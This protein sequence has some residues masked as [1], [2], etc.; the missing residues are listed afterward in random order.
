MYITQLSSFCISRPLL[1]TLLS[2]SCSHMQNPISLLHIYC[3][4]FCF[5]L[6]FGFLMEDISFRKIQA[7]V[8]DSFPLRLWSQSPSHFLTD[9]SSSSLFRTEQC[10]V[11]CEYPMFFIRSLQ[12]DA[13]AAEQGLC[14]CPWRSYRRR[15]GSSHSYVPQRCK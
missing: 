6:Y 13:W 15:A 3:S 11:V 7:N 10:S 1:P 2:T 14:L 12:V 9:D 5:Y 4:L 8:S